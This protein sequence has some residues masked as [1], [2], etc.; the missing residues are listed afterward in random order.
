MRC[1]SR[2]NM[3]KIKKKKLNPWATQV[4]LCRS[5][6]IK[7]IVSHGRPVCV[8]AIGN[9]CVKRLEKT[10]HNKR[11]L[12]ICIW[13]RANLRL[14]GWANKN[15]AADN[16]IRFLLSTRLIECLFITLLNHIIHLVH[17]FATLFGTCVRKL[18]RPV[19]P[20]PC[21][22]MWSHYWENR[23]THTHTNTNTKHTQHRQ[24]INQA[25]SA[26]VVRALAG[27][28]VNLYNPRRL[29]LVE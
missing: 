23:Q 5:G 4:L 18:I 13:Q 28:N 12:W 29:W 17:V 26:A 21:V 20:M 24:M 16:P 14:K 15:S 19:F 6:K 22:W 25:L 1:K 27:S 7:T 10:Q 3:K 2:P 9:R 11:R 8:P